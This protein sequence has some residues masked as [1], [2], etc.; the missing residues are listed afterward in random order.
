MQRDMPCA[1]TVQAAVMLSYA[2]NYSSGKLCGLWTH[3]RGFWKQVEAL[4]AELNASPKGVAGN[5]SKMSEL[6]K[7]LSDSLGRAAKLDDKVGT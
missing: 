5:A 2:S 4:E 7:R 3:E 1:C 6:S